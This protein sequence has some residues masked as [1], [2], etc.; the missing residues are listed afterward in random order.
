MQIDRLKKS[1][2]ENYSKELCYPKVQDKWN[3]EN[4]SFGMCAITALIVND[5]F[6]GYIGKIY[7]EDV[8]HYFNVINDEIFDF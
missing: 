8:S 2:R 5:Y 3:I 1:L 7:V 4:K 6:G